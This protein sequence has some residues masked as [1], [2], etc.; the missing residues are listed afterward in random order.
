MKRLLIAI[1]VGF[2][3]SVLAYADD[4]A[5]ITPEELALKQPMVEPGGDAEA[6]FWEVKL[7]DEFGGELRSVYSHYVRIKIFTDRA[8]EQH[9][10][11]ELTYN[12]YS[13]IKDIEGRTIKPDGTILP[14][15]KDAIF[16]RSVAKARGLNI[17]AKSFALPGVEPGCIIEYRWK[18]EKPFGLYKRLQCQRSFAIQR[19]RYYILPL[20]NDEY[21]M[22]INGFNVKSSGLA[23]QKDGSFMT[24]VMNVPA[25]K[26]EPRMPPEDQIRMWI[27]LFYSNTQRD[28]PP[29]YWKK[30]GKKAYNDAKWMT[31][32]NDD[33]RKQAEEIVAGVSAPD[34]KIK[35]LFE[36]CKTEIKNANDDASFTAE[37]RAKLKDNDSPSDTL[38]RKVGTGHDIGTLFAA[39]ARAT[40]FDARYARVSDR[41]DYFFD[42]AFADDYFLT[43]YDIAIKMGENWQFY[44]PGSQHVEYGMLRWQEEGVKALITDPKEPFFVNTPVSAAERSLRKRTA[45]LSLSADGTLEGD[46]TMEY[47]GHPANELKED[48]DEESQTEHEKSLKDLMTGR[49]NT[50]EVSKASIENAQSWGK[51]LTYT[52]HIR[53][54]GYAQKTGKRLFFQPGFFQKG[55]D[56][57]FTTSERVHPVYFPYPWKEEDKISIALPEGYE[58]DAAEAP[59]AVSAGDTAQHKIGLRLS[60]R[61]LLFDRSFFFRGVFFAVEMYPPIKKFFEVVH[62]RD[63]HTLTLKQKDPGATQPPV[64]T[65]TN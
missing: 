1:V 26:E 11:V 64:P 49:M 2:F 24:E 37:Q 32:Q 33:I 56:P 61:N 28:S 18:E 27:L 29:E 62:E 36:F 65:P 55:I 19:V 57:L 42:P 48:H 52:F 14:L 12:D 39:L 31:R 22:M 34:E 7:K 53:V 40:G 60:G 20:K 46:V 8:K 51:P 35:K 30:T 54:P 47:L 43:S 16:E 9:G 10:T 50:A 44:D 13:K 25:F 63:N 41:G 59:P 4:W 45:T 17:K 38:K 15:K 23:K 21:G 6:F 58:L 3:L 5:P